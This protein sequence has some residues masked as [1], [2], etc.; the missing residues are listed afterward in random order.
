MA[1]IKSDPVIYK[2]WLEKMCIRGANRRKRLREA[3]P[4]WKPRIPKPKPLPKVQRLQRT[5]EQS[6]AHRK[7]YQYE[8]N[9]R[10]EVAARRQA[11]QRLKWK[12]DAKFRADTRKRTAKW[13]ALN[14][15]H[16][17][18][19]RREYKNNKMKTDSQFQISQRI[20]ARILCAL[21]RKG[22][23]KA[24][25]SDMLLGCQIGVFEAHLVSQVVGFTTWRQ[26]ADAR[27]EIHHIIPCND[28]DMTDPFE[29]R[30][31]FNWRNTTMLTKLANLQLGD[32]YPGNLAADKAALMGIIRA[33]D[34]QKQLNAP[35]P[36]AV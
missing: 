28:W 6:K 19:V 4:N 18:K 26:L 9:N 31:C 1:K 25:K 36:I 34:T 17:K 13:F 21:K 12:T 10:P 32:E 8:Y 33:E 11:A 20:R 23:R 29:Q 24:Y 5:P 7:A 14:P 15:E 22:C 27:Y 30:C 16:G 2:A 3:D 35:Y